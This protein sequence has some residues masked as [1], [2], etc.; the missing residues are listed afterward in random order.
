LSDPA[1]FTRITEQVSDWG[2]E[3]FDEWALA[4]WSYAHAFIRN[5]DLQGQ[6]LKLFA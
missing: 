6:Y 1:A 2:Q 5:P 4:A 3:Q